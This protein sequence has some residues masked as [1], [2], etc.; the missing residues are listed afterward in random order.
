MALKGAP[1]TRNY[2]QQAVLLVKTLLLED[3]YYY[4]ASAFG[5]WEQNDGLGF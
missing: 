5:F 3:D 1:V 4:L 2:R